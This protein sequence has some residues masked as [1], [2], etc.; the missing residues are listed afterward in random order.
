MKKVLSLLLVMVM[1]LSLAACGSK[2]NTKTELPETTEPQQTTEPTIPETTAAQLSD[3]EKMVE[4]NREELLRSMEEAFATSSGMTCTSDVKVVDNGIVIDININ[5]LNNLGQAEKDLMQQ[6][7]QALSGTFAQLLLNLR[8][9]LPEVAYLAINVREVDGDLIATI[10][11]DDETLANVPQSSLAKIQSYLD[12]NGDALLDIFVQSFTA[13]SGL[14]CD[15]EIWAVGNGIEMAISINELVD[16][17]RS[18]KD[19]LQ[20]TYDAMQGEFDPMLEALQ[21]EVPEVDYMIIYVCEVDGDLAAYITVDGVGDPNENIFAYVE[22]N[23]EEMISSTEESFATSSGMTCETV[24]DVVGNGIVLTMYIN[25]LDN[26]TD[27]QKLSVQAT[28][29]TMAASFSGLMDAMHAE[30]PELEFYTVNVCE[31]D[32]DVIAAIVIK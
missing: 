26:L 16:L 19:E 12:A 11:A 9:E 29:D 17:S 3:I 10:R 23:Y 21:A 1:I 14:T 4:E 20:G 32:G 22:Q 8:Q 27:E 5:E 28:Y 15:A 30:L 25:E 7:Y 13:E 2:K 18:E 31:A 6:S 24:L